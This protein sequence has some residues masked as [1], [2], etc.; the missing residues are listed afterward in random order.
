MMA[1]AAPAADE[2]A[3][4]P[5]VP[6]NDAPSGRRR[7][8]LRRYAPVAAIALGIVIIGIVASRSTSTGLP[9]DPGSTAADGTK[10]LALI[11]RESGADVSVLDS[12][13]NLEVDSLLVLVDNLDDGSA[14]AIEAFAR[15]GGTLLVADGSGRLS[16][17]L[18][19]A[20]RTQVGMFSPAL[21]R[22]CDVP[23]LD[24]VERVRTGA[25]GMFVV[26]EGATG[27]F[28][29]DE[30]AWLLLED[31][32]SGTKIT[33]PAPTFLLN[34]FIGDV[35][36]APLA[37][38]LLAPEPGTDVGILRPSFSTT[39]ST[40]AAALFDLIPIRVRAAMGQLTIA[41]A[42]VVLWRMRR[43]GKPVT[44]PQ[45]VRLAGSELVI[46][47]GNLFQR[48]GARRRTAELLREDFRRT[49]SSR[50]G[51]PADLPAEELAAAAAQRTGID[52]QLVRAA[53]EGPAPN[54][55]AELL[56]LAQHVQRVRDAT[57]ASVP[58][59]THSLSSL[60]ATTTPAGAPSVPRQ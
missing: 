44:E 52:A 43:L 3:A 54:S 45:P 58:P 40:G 50:L 14:A 20:G 37:V 19:P 51:V 1:T 47:L 34:S 24:Q 22:R 29:R 42:F 46:A 15:A 30:A 26:P 49:V 38:A 56:A 6:Q 12:A 48:T 33:T 55:D 18:R 11:L 13:E 57:L 2:A 7:V 4:P 16:D 32:G 39:A 25:A 8:L 10:A 41:F 21:R 9:L 53:V 17:E 35:D 27:C 5:P 23:A 28:G 60:S 59:A 31:I 36:N